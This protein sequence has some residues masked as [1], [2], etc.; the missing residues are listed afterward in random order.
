MF[1]WGKRGEK[2]ADAIFARYVR[3][4][5]VEAMKSPTFN[6][7]LNELTT[8]DV[9]FILVAV[10]GSPNGVGQKLG[11]IA[12]ITV[13]S[14][15]YVDCLFSNLAVLVDGP[16]SMTKSSF[17]PR[18]TLLQKLKQAFPSDVKTVYGHVRTP[19]GSYGGERRTFGA[20]LPNFTN[21]VA[22]LDSEPYGTHLEYGAR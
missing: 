13:E 5:L 15:W 18:A 8:A 19:W 12:E 14:G 10:D 20:M 2:N 4:E 1:G 22:Q 17:E 3:P 16:I 6:P 21:M 9:N 11:K 7:N